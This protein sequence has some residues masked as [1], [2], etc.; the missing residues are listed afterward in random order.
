MKFMI[1]SGPQTGQVRS[2]VSNPAYKLMEDLG[3]IQILPD[4]TPKPQG[5]LSWKVCEVPHNGSLFIGVSCSCGESVKILRPSERAQWGHC[6]HF[7]I[8]PKDIFERYQRLVAGG[9]PQ[10]TTSLAGQVA[11]AMSEEAGRI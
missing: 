4:E 6:G 1:L 11:R 3:F 2:V 5:K 9:K 10:P 8:I 7:E